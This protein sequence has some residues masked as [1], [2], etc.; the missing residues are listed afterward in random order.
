MKINIGAG[1]EKFEGFVTID[2][3]PNCKPDYCLDI[4]KED[5]PFPDNSVDEVI[6]LHVLEHLG[7]GYFHVLQ[8]LYRVCKHGAMISIRVPHPKHETFLADP[9]HRRPITPLGLWIFSKKFNDTNK[10]TPLSKLAYYYNVDFEILDVKEIPEEFY[11]KAFN[12]QPANEVQRYI[13]EHNGIIK[14][15]HIRLVVIKEYD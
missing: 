8:E 7:E 12:G 1:D 2:H 3:D 4:E 13:T 5:L 15:F 6:A 10:E 11:I 14:E 9:T